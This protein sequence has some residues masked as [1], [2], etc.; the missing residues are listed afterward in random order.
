MLPLPRK[1]EA[2]RG[3]LPFYKQDTPVCA[4]IS[5]SVQW[6]GGGERE[7]THSMPGHSAHA[8][9]PCKFFTNLTPF[10]DMRDISRRTPTGF[11][12][13]TTGWRHFV[14]MNQQLGL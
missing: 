3:T 11:P 2:E 8:G 9:S 6:H 14:H 1:K 13:R 7:Q 4:S 10:R 12:D 5:A